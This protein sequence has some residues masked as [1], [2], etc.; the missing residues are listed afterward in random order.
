[1]V[2]DHIEVRAGPF[3]GE[4][5][6]ARDSRREREV[7]GV[8]N[9]TDVGSGRPRAARSQAEEMDAP[10]FRRDADEIPG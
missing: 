7:N 1:M 2:F 8:A 3:F 4:W 10:A 6:F 5:H 9:Y